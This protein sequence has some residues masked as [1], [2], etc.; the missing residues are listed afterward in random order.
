MTRK[1][2]GKCQIGPARGL[3]RRQ[4]R[5]VAARIG[6]LHQIAENAVALQS[7]FRDQCLTALE[8]AV[9]SSR[10]DAS[11]F[12]G[13]RHGEAGGAFLLDQMQCCVDQRLLE[14]AVVIAAFRHAR[15]RGRRRF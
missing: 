10:G 8:M 12:G 15:Y 7:A 1:L 6:M 5:W 11:A 3:E 4:C 13:L 14:I 2:A 9:H